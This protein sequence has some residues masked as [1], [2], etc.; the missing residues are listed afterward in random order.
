[1]FIEYIS[2]IITKYIL[3]NPYTLHLI[4]PIVKKIKH[5]CNYIDMIS[6]QQHKMFL[7]FLTRRFDQ[8]S[9]HYPHYNIMDYM[10]AC[11]WL[12]Q[13]EN[14]NN[15]AKI[16]LDLINDRYGEVSFDHTSD[17][18]TYHKIVDVTGIVPTNKA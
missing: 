13:A 18:W 5:K 16:V 15:A 7:V 10:D 4:C 2:D 9:G 12:I 3:K 17:G 8:E 11:E 14:E 6:P 1:M